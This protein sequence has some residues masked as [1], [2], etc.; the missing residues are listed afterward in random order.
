MTEESYP[1][2]L[3]HGPLPGWRGLQRRLFARMQKRSTQAAEFFRMPAR[4]IVIL[5]TSVE[6]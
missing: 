6:V 2:T 1:V 5:T 3:T 4:G